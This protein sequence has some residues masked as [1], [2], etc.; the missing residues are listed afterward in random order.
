VKA[1]AA[2]VVE[3][4]RPVAAVVVAAKG[5]APVRTSSCSKEEVDAIRIQ[6]GS[7]SRSSSGTGMVASGE[8]GGR[9]HQRHS[10]AKRSCNF[11]RE[12][13]GEDE[14]DDWERVPVS[15][16]LPH[17]GSQQRKRSGSRETTGGGSRRSSRS[18]GR[19]GEG[20]ASASCVGAMQQPGK[21]VSVSAR[22]KGPAAAARSRKR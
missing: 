21:M 20:T 5:P 11:D 9:G 1:K 6:C 15:R 4:V 16:P 17:R 2:A 13:S 8:T 12:R 10:G 18:P 14:E 3:E 22:E 19:R 7:L